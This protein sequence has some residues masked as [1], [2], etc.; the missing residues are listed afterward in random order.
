MRR[1]N[2][3]TDNLRR[4]FVP[5]DT[6]TNKSWIFDYDSYDATADEIG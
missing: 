3:K 1:Q 2:K 5:P 6:N 4:T